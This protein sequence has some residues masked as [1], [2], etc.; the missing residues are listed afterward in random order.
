[1]PRLSF[2]SESPVLVEKLLSALVVADCLVEP[3]GAGTWSVT[4]CA[5]VDKV[6]EYVELR[7]FLKAWQL[8]YGVDFAVL[9]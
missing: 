3:V 1:M 5:A 9:D 7:F 4:H 6:E 2:R 8:T